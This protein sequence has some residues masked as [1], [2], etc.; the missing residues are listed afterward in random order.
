MRAQKNTGQFMR[1]WRDTILQHFVPHVSQLTLV[2]DPDDL[3]TEELLAIELRQQGFDLIEFEDPVAFRYVYES[4]YRSVWDRGE[5]TG[6]MVIVRVRDAELDAL[7]YDLLAKGRRL[8]FDLGSLF[9]H[10]SG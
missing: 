7:P 1:N 10:L 6:L 8:A 4:N 2:A 5:S 3:L 9:P